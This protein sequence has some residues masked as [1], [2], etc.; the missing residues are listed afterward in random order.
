M[1]PKKT[2]KELNKVPIIRIGTY[3]QALIKSLEIVITLYIF[4]I[5]NKHAAAEKLNV[6]N[7]SNPLEK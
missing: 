2:A 3:S 5:G 7:N 4:I 1:V 6:I